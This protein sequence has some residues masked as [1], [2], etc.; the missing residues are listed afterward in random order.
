VFGP[1]P[2]RRLGRSLGVDLVPH[3]TCPYNCLYCQVGR[4]ERRTV[5]RKDW[6]PL[7]ETFEALRGKL[8]ACPDVITLSGSG[9]PTLHAGLGEAIRRIKAM[10]DVP[11]AVL[12][13]AALLWVPAV[14][15]ALLRA[16]FVFPSL[17]AG[18]PETFHAVNRP[19]GTIDFDRMVEGLIDFREIFKGRLNLEVFLLEGLNDSPAQVRKIASIAKRISPDEVQL[20]TVTRPPAEDSARPVTAEALE[21]LATL[22]DPPA[23]VIASFRS[24][25]RRDQGSVTEEAVLN[26]LRRRPCTLEDLAAGLGAPIDEVRELV[27]TL[28]SEMAIVPEPVGDRVYYKPA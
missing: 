4:T 20:N 11:L 12:T 19:H 3:K 26:I 2:S 1:V 28:S 15:E 24:A 5:E 13:N 27:E 8:D 7:P 10:T 22:F 9:E 21:A 25:S 18:D 23:K 17:D 6:V 14:R 16:D